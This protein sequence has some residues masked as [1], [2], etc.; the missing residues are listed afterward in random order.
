MK[1]HFA[2]ELEGG[3]YGYVYRAEEVDERIATLELALELPTLFHAGGRP[4]ADRWEEITGTREMTTRVMCDWIRGVLGIKNH[5][6]A[7]EG[8]S[9]DSYPIHAAGCE[10]MQRLLDGKKGD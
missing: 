1:K 6:P 4:N 5:C 2:P 9:R 10:T 8:E 7:C 3:G